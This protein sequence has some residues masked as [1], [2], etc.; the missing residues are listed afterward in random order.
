MNDD[1]S[2]SSGSLPP[3]PKVESFANFS[4]ARR[5]SGVRTAA[6]VGA[7]I[8]YSFASPLVAD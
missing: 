3:L 5:Q 1:R 6:D 7:A 8:G 4:V 2:G